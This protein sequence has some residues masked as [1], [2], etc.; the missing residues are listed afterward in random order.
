VT[1]TAAVIVIVHGA[2]PEQPAPLHPVNVEP[3]LGVAVS[4]TIVFA[5][6]VSSQS[7]PQVMPTGDEPTEPD[8]LPARV[9]ISVMSFNANPAVIVVSPVIVVAHAAVP[10]HGPPHPMKFD[11]PVGV[12]ASEIIVP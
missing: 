12:A 9:T 3:V 7:T 8:P 10:L 11:N 4:V 1:S 6:Y 5:T 2:V